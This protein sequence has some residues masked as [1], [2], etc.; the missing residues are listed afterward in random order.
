[1]STSLNENS[2]RVKIAIFDSFSKIVMRN[3]LRNLVNVQRKRSW[4]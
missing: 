4:F 2:R 3:A 1:M